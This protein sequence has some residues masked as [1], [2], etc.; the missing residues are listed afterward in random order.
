MA[1]PRAYS[2][3]FPGVHKLD[4]Y[5][6]IVR[7]RIEGVPTSCLRSGCWTRSV[8]RAIWVLIVVIQRE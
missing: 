3:R 6:G 4:R 7:A 2:P 1:G 8:R 5:K